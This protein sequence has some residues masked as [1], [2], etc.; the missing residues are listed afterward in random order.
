MHLG[1]KQLL[2]FSLALVCILPV[3]AHNLIAQMSDQENEISEDDGEEAGA[4]AV[5]EAADGAEEAAATPVEESPAVETEVEENNAFAS[6]DEGSEGDDESISYL[7]PYRE[8][9]SSWGTFV[10]VGYSAYSPDDYNPSFVIDSFS[11]YY[12][13]AETPLIELTVTPKKNFSFGS[14]GLDIGVGYYVNSAPDSSQLSVIP[15]RLGLLLSLDTLFSEPYVVPYATIGGYTM[16][17]RESFASQ[18]V[19]GNTLVGVYY[20]AGL[21]LQLDWIDQDGDNASYDENGMENTFLFLEAKSYMTSSSSEPD[22][23][24]PAEDPFSLGA[25][26][27][28]EF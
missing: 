9:R 6:P 18:A 2:I 3:R 27:V 12:G 1:P 15:V 22:L 4:D 11:G 23:G 28:L 16:L 21:K 7:K 24:S 17:Y 20:S 14:L 26:F 25:G 13:N 19:S 5:E 8:R 10:A